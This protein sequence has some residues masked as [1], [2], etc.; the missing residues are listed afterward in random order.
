MQTKKQAK[1]ILLCDDDDTLVELMQLVLEAEGYLVH[2][3][4]NGNE[5]LAKYAEHK[6]DL[7]ILDLDMPQKTGFEVLEAMSGGA[8]L[9]GDQLI[10]LSAIEKPA[11]MS[12]AKALGADKFLIKPFETSE[13]IKEIQEILGTPGHGTH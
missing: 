2:T 8:R 3:A 10:V 5:G 9:K 13:F 12:R 7:M 11:V 1:K 6:P 4:L